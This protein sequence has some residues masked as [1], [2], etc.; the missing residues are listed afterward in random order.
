MKSDKA[1]KG[2]KLNGGNIPMGMVNGINMGGMAGGK[3]VGG[4]GKPRGN[5]W[6]NYEGSGDGGDSYGS[7]ANYYGSGDMNS[8]SYGSESGTYSSGTDYV[9]TGSGGEPK[10]NV[11]GNDRG[12]GNGGNSYYS[13]YNYDSGYET[14]LNTG[15][16][17]QYDSLWSSNNFGGEKGQPPYH[18]NSR[19]GPNT[20]R[21]MQGTILC[22]VSC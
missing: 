13:S 17:D 1:K 6:G 18:V 19:D 12:K 16:Q 22:Q 3:V 8:G 2:G 5:I 15:S 4:L 7:S 21:N 10:G 9:P 11:W 20:N 14:Y